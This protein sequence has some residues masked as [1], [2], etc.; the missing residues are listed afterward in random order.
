MLTKTQKGTFI[1]DL[2][3]AL[4]H[5]DLMSFMLREAII[6][7][8]QALIDG[9]L[10]LAYQLSAVKSFIT[11]VLNPKDKRHAFQEDNDANEK[12]LGNSLYC[13]LDGI[14]FRLAMTIG[15]MPSGMMVV[16]AFQSG[17]LAT[18]EMKRKGDHP[19]IKRM[20]YEHNAIR[21]RAN[22]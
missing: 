19:I 18:E 7:T 13:I 12:I 11:G 17:A 4:K 5:Q 16:S 2:N 14:H 6:A 15:E 20:D 1:R 21:R 22:R 8:K 3:K 10:S 9:D